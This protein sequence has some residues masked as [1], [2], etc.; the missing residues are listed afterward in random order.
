M[1]GEFRILSCRPWGERGSSV[2][3]KLKG[4]IDQ[5]RLRGDK[6]KIVSTYRLRD[7]QSL[8]L[9]KTSSCPC[10]I[11]GLNEAH[12]VSSRVEAGVIRLKVICES[13]NEA[14]NILS[15]MR[16]SG[17]LVLSARLRKIREEDILTPRQEEALI[18]S[19]IRGYFDSPRKTNLGSLSK[20]LGVSKPTAYLMIKRA[21]KKLIKH[22]LYV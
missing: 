16:S 15:R 14:R 13:S 22:S 11:S 19:F 9:L 6:I 3:L 1:N 8:V 18:L 20:E 10:R 12:I 17:I 7:G 21:I 4:S 5:K 2:L